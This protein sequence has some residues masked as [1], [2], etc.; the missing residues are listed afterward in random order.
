[1]NT[2]G[3]I[4]TIFLYLKSQ[5]IVI[6]SQEIFWKNNWKGELGLFF[7][8]LILLISPVLPVVNAIEI[9]SIVNQVTTEA[10]QLEMV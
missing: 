10:F 4:S 1:M 7:V 6:F 2:T 3:A 5:T 9:E 8:I